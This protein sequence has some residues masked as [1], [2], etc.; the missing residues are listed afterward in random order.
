MSETENPTIVDEV[1]S[2]SVP[3]VDR[4]VVSAGGT[5]QDD[6]LYLSQRAVELTR[7][8]VADGAEILLLA[9][10]GDGIADGKSAYENFYLELM[11]N[12]Y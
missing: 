2:F 3:P 1:A 6:T 12:F 8:A 4:L 9:R 7:A 5:P 11:H 10:C